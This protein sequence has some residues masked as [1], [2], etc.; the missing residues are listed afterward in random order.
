MDPVK[1]KR[2]Y[3][4]K[5]CFDGTIGVQST[6]PF[7][8]PEDVAREVK[9]RITELG[10]TGLILG[11]THAMQPDVPVE[12]ILALYETALRYGWNTRKT[13]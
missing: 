8:T 13:V 4:D 7:G 11:P 2:L 1:L 3:G 10:P 9:Q 12:N 6:L 5:L